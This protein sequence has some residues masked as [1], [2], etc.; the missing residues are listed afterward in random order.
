MQLYRTM[1]TR[2]GNMLVG[3][4]M[5][6]KTTAWNVLADALRQVLQLAMCLLLGGVGTICCCQLAQ[7]GVPGFHGVE[8]SILNPK[9]LLVDE[10]CV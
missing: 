1:N 2:H 3:H 10:V 9:S 4:T 6:G 8:V 7:D 5:G